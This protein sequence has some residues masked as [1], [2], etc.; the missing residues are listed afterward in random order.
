MGSIENVTGRSRFRGGGMTA[1][2]PLRKVATAGPKG[3]TN[4]VLLL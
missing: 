4:S 3:A 1:R 2:S